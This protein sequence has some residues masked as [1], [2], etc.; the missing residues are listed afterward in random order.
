MSFPKRIRGAPGTQ[1]EDTTDRRHTLGQ[2]M[3][4]DDGRLFRYVLVGG[5]AL[6]CGDI[7]QGKP[8][9]ASDYTDVVVDVTAA[10]GETAISLTTTTTTAKDYYAGGYLHVNDA[11]V[12]AEQGKAYKI[13]SNVLFANTT[14]IVVT[15]ESWNPVQTGIAIGD[16]VGVTPDP[17]N[18]VIQAIINTVSNRIVGVAVTANTLTRYGWVQT[19]GVCGVKSQGSQVVGNITT[20]ILHTAGKCGVAS[21]GLDVT[22]GDVLSVTAT[23]DEISC[24]FLTLDN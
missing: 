11:A 1:Y 16:E 6:V 23:D 14:G 7:I 24:V 8:V 21:G 10:A 15:L 18:G 13:K 9:V 22:I 20:A 3:E 5:T 19:G 2:S 17:Y 12:V 4:I